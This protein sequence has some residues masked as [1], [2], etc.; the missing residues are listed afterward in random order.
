MFRFNTLRRTPLRCAWQPLVAVS[1]AL[2]LAGPAASAD[3]KLG[4][5]EA[6]AQ[7]HVMVGELA[8]LRQQP[9]LAATEFLKALDALP[10]PAL[11][12]RAASLALSARNEP[13]ALKAARRWQQLAPDEMD[14]RE[15]VARLALRAG[16]RKEAL[17]QCEAIIKNHPGGPED[18][19][20]Q[21]AQVLAQEGSKKEDALAIMEQLRKPHPNLAG[22]WHAQALLSLRFGQLD[23]AESAAREALKLKPGARESLL[24]LAGIQVKKGDVAAADRSIAELL[25]GGDEVELRMGYARLLLEA[26]QQEAGRAQFEQVLKVKPDSTEARYALGL[27][28]LEQQKLDEAE[29]HFKALL[30]SDE[31]RQRAAYY[32]GRIEE[33]RNRP[34]QALEWYQQVTEGEQAIDALTRRAVVL[35]KLGRIN[36]A[37]TLMAQMRRELPMFGQRFFLAEGELLLEVNAGPEALALYRQALKEIPDDPDLLYGRSLV[38]ERLRNVPEAEADLR[39]ILA[40]DKNDARAMNALGYMLVV[41]TS[42]L[43]EARSLITRALEITPDDAAVI[44]SLG[45]IEYRLG[46]VKEARTLL[47]RAFGKVPDPEIAAHLG[48]VLWVLGEKERARSIWEAALTRDPEHRVLKETMERLVR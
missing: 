19:F 10:D 21:A 29:P 11:A 42:R 36:E 39:R 33:V 22:A 4:S 5:A 45:W 3:P 25:K 38:H 37:R 27:L 20:R 48:E 28:A 9:E 44:D 47:E 26:E 2:A 8:A 41:H 1:L 13:L 24:L 30:E 35:G 16:D 46:K 34:A 17:T 32:L 43:D 23:V 18:G 6:N 14:P 40:K 31:L 15:A 7:Y 12:M